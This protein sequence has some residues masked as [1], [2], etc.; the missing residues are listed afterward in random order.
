MGNA[1]ASEPKRKKVTRQ[2]TRPTRDIAHLVIL[3]NRQS[4]CIT[5]HSVVVLI[6][7]SFGCGQRRV[8]LSHRT[9]R[10]TRFVALTDWENA[11][12]WIAVSISKDIRRGKKRKTPCNGELTIAVDTSP[13]WLA[14]AQLSLWPRIPFVSISK[15]TTY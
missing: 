2:V 3:L 14:L 13:S 7:L 10:S 15:R 11:K 5:D 8:L 12:L 6:T 4:T 9:E 1:Q